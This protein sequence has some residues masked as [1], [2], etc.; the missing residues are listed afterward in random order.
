MAYIFGDE[1]VEASPSF[2]TERLGF[3]IPQ[4]SFNWLPERMRPAGNVGLG[5]VLAEPIVDI[6]RWFRTPTPGVSV[7]PVNMREIEQNLN[8]L[9]RVATAGTSYMEGDPA[10]ARREQEALPGWAKWLPTQ[11]PGVNRVPDEDEKT[12]NRYIL[13][14]IR[15]LFPQLGV[16]ERVVPGAGTE[17]HAGRWFTSL[18]SSVL[19]LPANTVDGWVRASEQERRTQMVKDQMKYMYGAESSQYRL[20]L[21][22]T[23]MDAGAPVEFMEML[24]FA[25]MENEKIDVGQALATWEYVQRI[26]Y[27]Y[28]LGYDENEIAVAMNLASTPEAFN[29]EWLTQIYDRMASSPQADRNRFMREFGWKRLTP[30]ELREM[31]I[32]Q[33][34]LQ[35]MSDEELIELIRQNTYRKAGERREREQRP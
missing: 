19:G 7:N 31:G 16:V 22:R 32:S 27:L 29:T 33:L 1:N 34:Q 14:S 3:E 28:L 17:R 8:P 10:L 5:M 15:S 6:A 21:I 18:L 24:D 30:A 11:I 20:E 25:S 2:L 9:W 4:E 26:G 35:Q 13:E 12:T 23:L